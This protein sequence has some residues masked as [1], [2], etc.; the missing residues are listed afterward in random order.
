MGTGAY[1]HMHMHAYIYIK[2]LLTCIHE[3]SK[4]VGSDLLLGG[5]TEEL[6][7]TLNHRREFEAIYHIQYIT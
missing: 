6:V 3:R 5:H 2:N 4:P 1:K 7:P